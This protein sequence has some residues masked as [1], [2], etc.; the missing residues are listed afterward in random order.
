MEALKPILTDFA[1]NRENDERFGDFC[2]RKEYVK[3]TVKGSDF[4]IDHKLPS[5]RVC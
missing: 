3:A 4:P 1:N 2:I 5:C